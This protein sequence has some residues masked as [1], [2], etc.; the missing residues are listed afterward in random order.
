MIVM[1][2]VCVDG[3][4]SPI[5]KIDLNATRERDSKIVGVEKP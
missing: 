3:L 4:R 5:V 1:I 2:A